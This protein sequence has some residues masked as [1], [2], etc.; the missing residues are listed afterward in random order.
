M[1]FAAAAGRARAG[2]ASEVT[3]FSDRSSYSGERAPTS[4]APRTGGGRA[5][6]T[7][8]RKPARSAGTQRAGV[9]FGPPS[10]AFR[11]VPR[12]KCIDGARLPSAVGAPIL[13]RLLA[14]PAADIRAMAS[15]RAR[16]SLLNHGGSRV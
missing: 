9:D 4:G 3:R 1:R 8:R 7:R 16:N 10:P 15:F 11:W 13:P 12:A 5:A 14:T 2:E 6:T